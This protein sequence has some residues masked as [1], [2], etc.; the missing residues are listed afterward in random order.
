MNRD[1]TTALALLALGLGAIG[2]AASRTPRGSRSVLSE[3]DRR[4]LRAMHGQPMIV[5]S[6]SRSLL[7][8]AIK[9]RGRSV[10][11]KVPNKQV[12]VESQSQVIRQTRQ[13][14]QLEEYTEARVDASA[15]WKLASDKLYGSYVDKPTV[16]LREALQNS[17][18]A[19]KDAM[20][21][22]QIKRGMFSV[23]WDKDASSLV[24]EDNGTGMSKEIVKTKF[25]SLGSST[26]IVTA[27]DAEIR[28]GGFGLAKAVILGASE[29]FNWEMHTQ[30]YRYLGEGFEKK[31]PVYSAPYLQG[32]KLTLRDIERKFSGDYY[33][34]L[35]P[36]GNLLD[37]MVALLASSEVD[38][39]MYANGIEIRRSFE[40]EGTPLAEG[41]NWGEGVVGR[42][43]AFE[44]PPMAQ[45]G[46]VWVRLFGLTQFTKKYAQD[47]SNVDVVVDLEPN[48]TP[49]SEKYPFTASR[50]S[51]SGPAAVTL[52]SLIEEM[53]VDILSALQGPGAVEVGDEDTNAAKV[54]SNK[55]ELDALLASVFGDPT[56]VEV[57]R[58]AEGAG[59]RA[60]R[61]MTQARMQAMEHARSI[62]QQQSTRSRSTAGATPQEFQAAVQSVNVDAPAPSEQ[63]KEQIKAQERKRPKGQGGENPWAG[64]AML[65][66]NRI[67]WPQSRFQP[68]VDNAKALMPLIAAWRMAILLVAS[69]VSWF[70]K[71]FKVGLIFDDKTRAEYQY[72]PGLFS[73]NPVAVMKLVKALPDNP[74]VIAAYLHNKACH[75]ITH[76]TGKDQH[77]EAFSSAREKLADDTAH[78]I[79]PLTMIVRKLFGMGGSASSVL[80]SPSLAQSKPKKKAIRV[81]QM[82]VEKYN[83][84][85][86]LREQDKDQP[87]LTLAT[88]IARLL[89]DRGYP[90]SVEKSNY[91]DGRYHGAVTVNFKYIEE[92]YNDEYDGSV[93][94]DRYGISPYVYSGDDHEILLG[95]VLTE[96]EKKT[97]PDRYAY[98][99]TV[100]PKFPVAV[101]YVDRLI[102]QFTSDERKQQ[103]TQALPLVPSTSF[104]LRPRA[105]GR[106]RPR[107]EL[108]AQADA[109]LARR[110]WA[111]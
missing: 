103:G 46:R 27:S 63:Q 43:R 107:R 25:L 92:R 71:D 33:S 21:S 52:D 18:D 64:A 88:S 93:S 106:M 96:A 80:S 72:P 87:K 41:A 32:V 14:G 35:T 108:L 6:G 78:L 100:Y 17:R 42:V 69:R 19:I 104:N 49:R 110:R 38:F 67:D 83:N 53:S 65:K 95:S 61:A 66:I 23:T 60:N 84:Q 15:M 97:V 1:D 24:F 30:D 54:A 105:A 7:S 109:V 101:R 22:G 55:S 31:I 77:D 89:T 3:Q 12:R 37:R 68:Y 62:P 75:E 13:Q 40:G 28:A 85:F 4:A 44:R 57:I 58:A 36:G 76:S 79:V 73:L 99:T 90:A 29:T 20:A 5:A 2:V 59:G 26:K 111:R 45:G 91:H 74:D 48:M 47:K 10:P 16:A 81:P 86:Q 39:P 56:L 8:D 102:K 82:E 34:G 94:V 98:Y 70:D 9:P 51:L 50:M 11:Q